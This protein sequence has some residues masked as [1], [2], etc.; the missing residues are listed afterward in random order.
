[1]NRFAPAALLLSA[2]LGAPALAQEAAPD[3]AKVVE[4][5]EK[6]GDPAKAAA[7]LREAGVTPG[8]ARTLLR[9]GRPYG[10]EATGE[11]LV[12][13]TAAGR[14]TDCAIIVPSSYDPAKK[15]P[16]V[17][18]LHGLGGDYRQALAIFGSLADER[19]FVMVAPS[20]G[21]P[22]DTDV[23]PFIRDMVWR[24]SRAKQWWSYEAESFPMAALDAAKSRLN[25]DEDRVFLTGY[26][27]GG[28]GSWNIG[29]RQWDRFAGAAPF[30]AGMTPA[31]AISGKQPKLRRLLDNARKLPFFVVHGEHDRLVPVA[32]SRWNVE[33]LKELECEHEY[34]E[35]AGAGHVL[36]PEQFQAVL[37]KLLD[38]F[39]KRER[40]PLARDLKHVAL[41]P[42][43]G[44]AGWA[45]I[46]E[47]EAGLKVPADI[48]A[49]FPEP[50]SGKPITVECRGVVRLTLFLPEAWSAGEP[51]KVMVNGL[52]AVAAERDPLETAADAWLA[53]RDRTRVFGRSLAVTVPKPAPK[54]GDSQDF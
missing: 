36:R 3:A 19:G 45:R 26:S 27:M 41:S 5:V 14:T 31:E 25:I 16:L 12:R 6:A 15:W 30:A 21:K 29:L 8:E 28:F 22:G 53:R 34:H 17:V 40:A 24:M 32:F 7:A 52:P 2:A 13:I 9:A 54:P 1:M 38:F 44:M 37:P 51:P 42:R 10:A 4:L 46:D 33:H 11:H 20:A 49:V 18:A 35:V 48:A 47:L 43:H 23:E 50:G 39:A